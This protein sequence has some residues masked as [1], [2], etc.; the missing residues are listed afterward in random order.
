MNTRSRQYPVL[1]V[2]IG[3]AVLALATSACSFLS[4][5]L[6]EISQVVDITLDEE[7]FSQSRPTFKLHDHGG[8]TINDYGGW[9]FNSHDHDI[10][11]DLDVD[12]DRME[13]HDGYLR[14]LGTRSMPDGSEAD[15]SI[16]MS[17]GAENG[18]LTA[19]IIAVDIPGIELSDPR[20][21]VINQDLEA[22]LSLGEFDPDAKVLF[23][24]VEV[25]EDALRIKVQ[26][27]VSF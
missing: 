1:F 2:V 16:D 6:G 22:T 3:L 9:T 17:L 7:L 21:V 10:W 27:D 4:P 13:L 11:E 5:R 18:M 23:R 20:I 12:V 24:E 26:V 25:T 8:W 15:C 19:R 14:F